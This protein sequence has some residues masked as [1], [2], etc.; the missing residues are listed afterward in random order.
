MGIKGGNGELVGILAIAS[1]FTPQADTGIEQLNEQL[2]NYGNG[3]KRL[4][5]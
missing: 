2:K 5:T 4:F 3:L 1:S